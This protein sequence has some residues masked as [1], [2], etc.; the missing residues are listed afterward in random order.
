[1]IPHPTP[2][3][4]SPKQGFQ[5]PHKNFCPPNNCSK[6]RDQVAATLV[7]SSTCGSLM[8]CPP[9]VCCLSLYQMMRRKRTK[10]TARKTTERRRTTTSR[11]LQRQ[12]NLKVSLRH[13]RLSVYACTS[14]SRI[15]LCKRACVRVCATLRVASHCGASLHADRHLLGTLVGSLFMIR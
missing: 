9:R 7:V 10:R 2:N 12:P 8:L 14:T 3:K 4:C 6:K 15:L 11:S 5:W 13:P 1:M